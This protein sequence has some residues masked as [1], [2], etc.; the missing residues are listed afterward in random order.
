A[1]V[2][3]RCWDLLGDGRIFQ[4]G[5]R[6]GDGPEFRW[7]EAGHVEMRR[8]DL[9]GFAQTVRAL[10]DKPLY[11]TVDLD[12]LDPAVFPGTGTPEAGGVTF[13]ELLTA[14]LA[15]QGANV[16]A[17]DLNELSPPYDPSGTSTATALKTLRELLLAI[18]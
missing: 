9:R 5:I 17:C 4:F 10:E 11:V 3:R 14:I 7:A 2:I 18:L 6:S 12:V 16:V 13:M 8:F 1:T 15:L